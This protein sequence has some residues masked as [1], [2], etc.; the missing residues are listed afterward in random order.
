MAPLVIPN[1]YAE[2]G[3][4][5]SRTGMI[6]PFVITFGVALKATP[7]PAGIALDVKNAW[8]FAGS[9]NASQP[10]TMT[11][12]YVRYKATYGGVALSGQSAAG[13][14]AG[15]GGGTTLCSPAVAAVIRKATGLAGRKYRGRCMLPWVS[16]ADVDTVGTV[17]PATV[18][19]YNT[20]LAIFLT[21]LGAAGRAQING[22]VLLHS[23]ATTP[24][25]VT[26]LTL[27][28]TVGTV[29]ERQPV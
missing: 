20:A 6:H 14:A 17:L 16:E 4:E 12:N 23:D 3:I 13:W 2:I 19:A 26:A 5:W 1:G 24:T 8:S 22:M 18:T 27:R 7:T 29:R 10:T 25:A 21:Q 15:G 9:M 11:A 28:A